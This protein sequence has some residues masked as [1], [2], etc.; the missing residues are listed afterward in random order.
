MLTG[1]TSKGQAYQRQRKISPSTWTR[2]VS[3]F[4]SSSTFFVYNLFLFCIATE[5]YGL[6]ISTAMRSVWICDIRILK[7]RLWWLGQ[8]SIPFLSSFD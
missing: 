7:T 3:K 1:R 8:L 5:T 6:T 4:N 2:V